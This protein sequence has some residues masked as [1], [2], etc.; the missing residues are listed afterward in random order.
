MWDLEIY[1][2]TLHYAAT[3]HNGQMYP[4][5]S[6]PYII[7]P[8]Q[9]A[10]VVLR[11]ADSYNLFDR[12]LALQTALLHDVLEDT[13]T[14]F[15]ELA[16]KFGERV[17]SGVAALSKNPL[18]NKKEQML[19]SLK[20]IKQQ[21]Q[22]IWVVKLADRACNLEKPPHYWT[23]EKCA[24]YLDEAKIILNTL[25]EVGGF[26]VEEIQRKIENYPSFFVNKQPPHIAS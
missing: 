15:T 1:S 7:H 10:N 26:I 17:A 16:A 24:F 21:P 11:A 12:N 6:L 23:A 8:C 3:K 14:S 4:G 20:R 22:E 18:L 9:V 13:E 19:D 25:G 5:T 2:D